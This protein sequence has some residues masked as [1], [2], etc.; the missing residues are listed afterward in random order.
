MLGS[1]VSL[2]LIHRLSSE[3]LERSQAKMYYAWCHLCYWDDFDT[4]SELY[5]HL[6][7]EHYWCSVCHREEYD[8]RKELVHH[9]VEEHHLCSICRTYFSS[10]SN[11]KYVGLP[12]ISRIPYP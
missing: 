10:R 7:T 9:Q 11:L 1:I 5:E 12:L 4:L 6:E 8:T 3:V 2:L